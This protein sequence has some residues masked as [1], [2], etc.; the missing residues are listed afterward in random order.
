MDLRLAVLEVAVQHDLSAK[1]TARLN[2]LAGLDAEPSGV[3]RTVALG[4]AVLAAAL[5]GLGLIFWVAAN[6]NDFGRAGRFGLLQGLVVVMCVAAM[7]RPAARVPLSVVALLSIGGLFAYFGQTYQ[8]GADPW[9]LFAWWAVLALPLCA[10]VRHDA[11]WAPWALVA[12]TAV[13]LWVYANSG[14]RWE[15]DSAN[16]TVHLAG[17]SLALLIAFALSPA[18]RRYTG[19]GDV[20]M[21]VALVLAAV[22]ITLTS[23]AG[24]FGSTIAPHFWLGLL[25]LGSAAGAFSRPQFHDT[26]ALSVMGLGLNILLVGLIAQAMIS[27]LNWGIGGLLVT[28]LAAA[29][30]LAGT[31][32]VI[33]SLARSNAGEQS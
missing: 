1:Q 23:V 2:T 8:T 25:M 33:L 22:M 10:G 21:R 28:G 13:S 24:L 6:W 27:D 18:L 32:Q 16:L 11:L 19:A 29:A 4:L 3:A 15:V 7:L 30:L 31:V 17:W 26:F 14:H 20:A 5:G 12:V 9:Q